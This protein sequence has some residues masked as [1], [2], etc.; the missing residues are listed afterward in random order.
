MWPCT[1]QGVAL[2]HLHLRRLQ[3]QSRLRE[4]DNWGACGAAQVRVARFIGIRRSIGWSVPWEVSEA[5]RAVVMA[6][7]IA[8]W[9]RA[10][11]KR[12]RQCDG[13]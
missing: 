8:S 3:C 5:G 7:W 1:W 4:H 11:G 13:A 10:Q 9:S 12:I 6:A 2:W